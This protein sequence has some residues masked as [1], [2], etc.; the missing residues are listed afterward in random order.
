MTDEPCCEPDFDYQ[1][2]QFVHADWCEG[3]E[4]MEES[5]RINF[6]TD[7]EGK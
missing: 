5:A 4:P 6:T 2:G 3:D 7:L 1:K